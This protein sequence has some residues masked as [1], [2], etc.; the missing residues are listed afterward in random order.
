MN[1][2]ANTF[3]KRIVLAFTILAVAFMFSACG[4]KESQF[5]AV[6]VNVDADYTATDAQTVKEI[7]EADQTTPTGFRISIDMSMEVPEMGTMNVKGNELI[8][9]V[10]DNDDEQVLH[11]GM[12]LKMEGM[13]ESGTMKMFQKLTFDK[14]NNLYDLE[15][16]MSSN[17]SEGKEKFKIILE[18]IDAS[19][20]AENDMLGQIGM[21]SP[22][23]TFA[24]LAPSVE[25]LASATTI[26]SA[27]EGD[28]TKIKVVT[29]IPETT[30]ET[31][32]YLIYENGAFDK[33][34]ID[35]TMQQ[36]V[37]EDPL[38][39]MNMDMT[40]EGE[41]WNGDIKFPNPNDYEEMPML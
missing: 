32:S 10:T 34:L 29:P 27:T 14:V 8:K 28:I 26:E 5:K 30:L 15:I 37:S 40:I 22:E 31:T 1:T 23:S 19:E 18:D 24:M 9:I 41:V 7:I 12:E 6:N 4:K 33:V 3:F 36:V 2:K 25:A 11:A 35:T 17:S 13:G 21:P 16:Y 39:V 20:L 38:M